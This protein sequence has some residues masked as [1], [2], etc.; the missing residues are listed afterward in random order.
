MPSFA[1]RLLFKLNQQLLTIS[2]IF[3]RLPSCII[4]IVTLP[5]NQVF[6]TVFKDTLLQYFLNFK[7]LLIGNKDRCPRNRYST[8]MRFKQRHMKNIMQSAQFLRQLQFIR[9]LRYYFRYFK[10]T[11]IFLCKFFC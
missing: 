1:S 2:Q 11:H 7:L 9:N 5:L 6:N 10:W 3:K 4:H 8:K